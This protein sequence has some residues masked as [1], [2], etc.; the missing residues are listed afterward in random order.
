M[1]SCFGLTVKKC[2]A[3]IQRNFLKCLV[4]GSDTN[5]GRNLTLYRMYINDYYL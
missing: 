1:F 3:A 2:T 4:M 5:Q